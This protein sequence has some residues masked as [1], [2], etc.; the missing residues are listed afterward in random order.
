MGFFDRKTKDSNPEALETTS[1][2][3]LQ[4]EKT[5]DAHIRT[6]S[7]VSGDEKP[8]PD[9]DGSQNDEEDPE[10]EYPTSIKLLLITIALCLTV[11]CIALDNTIIAT[12]IPKITDH[13]KAIDDIA[14]YGSAYLLTTC[15]FQLFFGKLYSFLSLKWV[16][17]VALFIFEL[18]SFVCGIAPTSTALIVGRAIAG[19]G[20]AGLFSGAILIIANSVPL[21]KRPSYTGLIGAMYGLASVAGPLMGGAFTDHLT[22][23]WCF[24]IN[25]PFGAVTMIFIFFFFNPTKSAKKLS[26]GWKNRVMDFDPAGTVIFLPMIICLLLALQWGGSTYPWSSGRVIALFV[27]FGVLLAIF[28][29][30][31]FYVGEKAT[32]PPRIIKQRTVAAS[33]WFGVS[34]GAA[35]FL[36]VYYLPI[37]FQAIKG[38][39]ATKSGIMSLPLILGVVICSVVAGGLVTTFGFYSPFMIASSILMAIG[40]GLLTTFKV[41]TGHAE[42]IGYQALFGIGVGLGMQQILIAVQTVLP[43]ADIPTGTAIVM[44]FQTLGGALFISVGQNVFT[45][46]LVSGLKAAVP[47]LDPAIVLSTGATELKSAIGEQYRDGVLQAYNDALTNSYYV[48][49]ALATLSIIGSAAVEWKSVKGKKIEMTAA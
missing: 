18:G 5:D 31:Q 43:A 15:S 19:V 22:W 33:A 9:S 47:D 45:N 2:S 8:L 30:I 20:S 23:R 34:L 42:W 49:V 17:L 48:A 26:V 12:A 44:F 38:V 13:F 11:F 21:R 6:A 39:S 32:I 3:V 40:A 29:S 1:P 41:D 46:K 14:W 4:S 36:F 16:F 28:V 25:L 7:V 24:Y 10:V 27:V 37:W 35:F